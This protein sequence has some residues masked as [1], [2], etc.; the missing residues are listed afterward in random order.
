[1]YKLKSFCSQQITIGKVSF[2]TVVQNFQEHWMLNKKKNVLA[3]PFIKKMMILSHLLS[4]HSQVEEFDIYNLLGYE[5]SS[6]PNITE[7]GS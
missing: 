4:N 3:F 2:T 5:W 1:M 7:S 6:Q